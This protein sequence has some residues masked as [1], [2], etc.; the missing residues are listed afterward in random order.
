MLGKLEKINIREIW[1][2]EATDFTKW[3]ATEENLSALGDE[4]GIGISLIKTEAGVGAFSA[5]ILAEEENTGRKIVIEN[6]LEQT[7]HDHFGKLFTYGSGHSAS[8]L[9]WVC[10]EVRD[11]HRQA[12]DWL[13][14]R[15][16]SNLN[17]FVIK[18]EV[19]KIGDSSPAPK[20][21]II[22]SPNNWAKIMKDPVGGKLSEINMLQLDFWTEFNEYLQEIGSKLKSRKPQPHHWYDITIEGIP[23]TQACLSLTVSFAKK[24]I[25]CEFYIHDNKD[26]YHKIYQHKADIEA[27]LGYELIWDEL[28]QA[29]ASSTHIKKE[30][31][32]VKDRKTWEGSHKWIVDTAS[33]FSEVFPK[34][35]T[36]YTNSTV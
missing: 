11:E 23:T 20:F 17:I 27:E 9:I 29:K 3:L 15:T 18:M 13:N 19:W 28:P 2:N 26:L 22:C 30:I 24:F 10:R 8:I 5:D 14:E 1:K 16:D 7:D 25:R 31:L 4:I 34:Y 6:Q 32:K 21:Q 35:Y 12:I 33:K 36:K